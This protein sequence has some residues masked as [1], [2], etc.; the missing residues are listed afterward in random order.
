MKY[1]IELDLEF[2]EEEINQAFGDPE[3]YEST[4]QLYLQK[5]FTEKEIHSYVFS[6]KFGFSD[7]GTNNPQIYGT[8]KIT[9]PQ[10]KVIFPV[11]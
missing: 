5:L 8:C 3:V 7:K 1:R 10:G 6:G 9:N 11:K 2:T 4:V